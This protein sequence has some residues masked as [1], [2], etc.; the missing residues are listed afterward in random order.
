MGYKL[1][2]RLQSRITKLN[3]RDD[4]E[5]FTMDIM[6]FQNFFNPHV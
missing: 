4:N 6:C 3:Y 5:T 1:G 2:G